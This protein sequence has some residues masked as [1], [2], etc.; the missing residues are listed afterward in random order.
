[1]ENAAKACALALIWTARGDA[2]PGDMAFVSVSDGVGVGLVVAGEVL[3]GRH[4]IAGEYGHVPLSIEGPRCACGATGCWEAYV[5]NLATLSRYVDRPLE[6]RQPFSPDLT[7]TTVGD[8]IARARYGDVKALTA[9]LATGRYLG[10]GLASIVNSLDP[11]RIHIGGEITAAWDVIEPTVRSALAE[12][13]IVKAAADTEIVP[14]AAEEH[15]RLRG[16]SALVGSTA[17]SAAVA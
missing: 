1:M 7:R 5:S 6:P 9:L 15:P 14:V 2:P 4:N 3:R 11:A 16:A 8:V 17:F 10:L 12:R 13:V